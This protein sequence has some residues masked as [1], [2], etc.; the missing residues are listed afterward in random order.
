MRTTIII[1]FLAI[2]GFGCAK[3]DKM[4]QFNIPYTVDVFIP[5]NDTAGIPLN[6]NTGLVNT[7]IGDILKTYNTTSDKIEKIALRDMV[8]N[9]TSPS[10]GDLEFL[11]DINIFIVGNGTEK[12]LASKTNIGDNI[13]TSL[14]LNLSD[15]DVKNFLFSDQ[16]GLRIAA[17]TD[18]KIAPSYSCTVSFTFF[19]DYK[20][21]GQ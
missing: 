8:I 21:L 13:G 4:G 3:V 2:L 9:V 18:K 10:D 12:I 5:A 1:A 7:G 19:V 14:T 15:N 20:L 11:K 16:F 6:I 17:E